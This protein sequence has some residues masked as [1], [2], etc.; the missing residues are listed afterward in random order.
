MLK[1]TIFLFCTIVFGGI[2]VFIIGWVNGYRKSE[3][4]KPVITNEHRKLFNLK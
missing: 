1:L 2:T 4:S 3:G